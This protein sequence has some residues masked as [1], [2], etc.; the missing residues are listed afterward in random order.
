MLGPELAPW[1]DRIDTLVCLGLPRRLNDFL[2]D[3][4]RLRPRPRSLGLRHPGA[5]V[6]LGAGN[7]HVA[8]DGKNM[9]IC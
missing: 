1:I 4:R 2:G 6:R 7:W 9:L 8:P 5:M 3:L